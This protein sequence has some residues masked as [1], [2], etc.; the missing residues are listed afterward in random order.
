MMKEFGAYGP[1]HGQG[2][3]LYGVYI[4]LVTDVQ[5]PAGQGRVRVRLPWTTDPDG[6]PYEAW[7]RLATLMAGANRGTWFIPEPDDEVLVAFQG[8]DA[9]QPVVLGG[10]WNG[11]DSPPESMDNDNN[12]RSITSRSGIKITMDDTSGSVQLTLET[13]GGQ[14]AI[15]SDS[16]ASIEVSDSNGNS[17]K[18]EA[19]GITFN[20]AGNFTLNAS[21]VK[22]SAGM[23]TVDAG[24]S[25]FSGVV[26][27]DTNITNSTVS[28]SYTPGA[29]NIW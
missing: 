28:V 2:G 27:S 29:G 3:L 23:V 1:L 9:G 18:L 13:P 6:D 22:V 21:M 5:D 20:T 16:P 7:A 15:F 24:M 17:M 19:S 8:G 25:K 4:A 14:Q 26:K 11:S 12:I 10:L